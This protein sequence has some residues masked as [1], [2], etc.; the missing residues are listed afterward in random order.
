MKITDL[1]GIKIQDLDNPVKTSKEC[2]W[3]G[4]PL[5]QGEIIHPDC[6]TEQIREN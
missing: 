3:C 6:F 2:T 4:K 5:K 1:Q